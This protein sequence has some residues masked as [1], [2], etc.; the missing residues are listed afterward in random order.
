VNSSDSQLSPQ[1]EQTLV[2]VVELSLVADEVVPTVWFKL[3]LATSSWMVSMIAI[4]FDGPIVFRTVQSIS[5]I[6]SEINGK[7]LPEI[8]EALLSKN[9]QTKNL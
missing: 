7:R 4:V 6:E 8:G 1:P 2:L 5:R 9:I 3:L